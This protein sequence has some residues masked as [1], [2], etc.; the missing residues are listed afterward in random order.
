MP[1]P[2]PYAPFVSFLLKHLAVGT[3][4]GLLLGALLLALAAARLR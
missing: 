2:S 3:A 4:G 1:T